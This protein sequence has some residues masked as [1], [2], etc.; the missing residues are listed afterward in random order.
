MI[1]H[2]WGSVFMLS[3]TC[4]RGPVYTLFIMAEGV[5][6]CSL[7]HGWE[8]VC[9][10]SLSWLREHVYALFFMAEEACVCSLYHYWGS[11][12]MLSILSFRKPL[13][14]EDKSWIF[15]RLLVDDD[16]DVHFFSACST[17]VTWMLSALKEIFF[18]QKKNW[19]D[20]KSLSKT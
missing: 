6:V 17:P 11:V 13:G 12:C 20:R 10:R 18:F 14:S 8:S 19:I 5:F 4:L 16:D 1:Y 9:M 2:G 7:C 3:L 15:F